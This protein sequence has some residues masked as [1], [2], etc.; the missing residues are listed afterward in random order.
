MIR[1][2]GLH[3][4]CWNI[5]VYPIF[6]IKFDFFYFQINFLVSYLRCI[7]L[8][9]FKL[10]VSFLGFRVFIYSKCLCVC[11]CGLL[12]C[13]F[14]VFVF[15]FSLFLGEPFRLIL[16]SCCHYLPIYCSY[17]DFPWFQVKDLH[18]I[19]WLLHI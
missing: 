18:A 16:H 2:H 3:A 19:H 12:F 14:F 5:I 13:F 6:V 15:F 11:V 1:T 8:P 7:M 10:M 17:K 9:W 4:I